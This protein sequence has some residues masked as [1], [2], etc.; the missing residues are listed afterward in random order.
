MMHYPCLDALAVHTPDA[1]HYAC[2][3]SSDGQYI[4]VQLGDSDGQQ[5]RVALTRARA[6]HL[7]GLLGRAMQEQEQHP[8]QQEG[9]DAR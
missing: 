1:A 2:A 8:H 6:G 5:V 7:C 3:L 9:G 4:L